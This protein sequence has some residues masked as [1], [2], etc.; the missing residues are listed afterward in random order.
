MNRLGKLV[1]VWLSLSFVCWGGNVSFAQ[2]NQ[3]RD[4]E[5]G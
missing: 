2:T 5:I 1:F 4:C 3:S